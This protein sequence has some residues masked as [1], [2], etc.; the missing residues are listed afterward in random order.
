ME[1]EFSLWMVVVAIALLVAFF[2]AGWFARSI[3]LRHLIRETR[4]VPANYFRGLH[5]LL[6][7]QQD[8]AID[9]FL[10]V[11]REHPQTVELQFAL[12]SLFRRR[13]EIDRAIRMHQDLTERADVPAADRRTART[14]VSRRGPAGGWGDDLEL[15]DRLRGTG[16]PSRPAGRRGKRRS[17]SAAV[18]GPR[19]GDGDDR[20]G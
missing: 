6:S 13:G 8:K 11:S 19:A 18:D 4:E 12:G 10:Q 1:I 16:C 2:A 5:Y 3:E 14:R 15:P 7:D 17:R 20:S 9:A